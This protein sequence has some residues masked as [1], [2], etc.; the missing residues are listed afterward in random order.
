MSTRKLLDG[1]SAPPIVQTNIQPIG[2]D[3]TDVVV[4]VLSTCLLVGNNGDRLD[5]LSVEV[6]AAANATNW[7]VWI[8]V[9]RMR[10]R[11]CCCGRVGCCEARECIAVEGTGND[12]NHGGDDDADD[13]GDGGR[14]GVDGRRAGVGGSRTV[15]GSGGSHGSEH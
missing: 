3:R 8:R 10:V 1:L 2:A 6:L 12:A 5:R 4:V 15:G 11:C 14:D 9:V 13:G 7:E